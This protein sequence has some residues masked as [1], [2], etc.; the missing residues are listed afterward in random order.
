MAPE[1]SV[2]VTRPEGQAGD[3]SAAVAAAGFSVHCLPM[4][5]LVPLPELAAARRQQVLDLDHYQHIIFVSGNAVRWGMPWFESLWPQLPVGLYWY[6]VGAA[7]ARQLSA[8]GVRVQTPDADMS[9]EGLLALPP[10]QQVAGQRVLI[11][12]GEGGRDHLAVEL[13]RRGAQVDQLPCYRRVRPG[14]APGELALKL[15]LWRVTLV[16]ISSGE[17]LAN[18][19]ALLS[20]AETS[21]FIHITLLVPSDRVAQMAYAAGF[22]KVVRA[23]NASDSAML[24]A[25]A[26]WKTSAGE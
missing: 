13:E 21:K 1:G 6:A 2:L 16:M 25:L 11:V 20:P 3:L 14:L 12:K 24:R 5:Q 19:L 4:L 7:T 18:M 17:G 8:F 22:K 10:L 15:S 9:S 23:E 26:A